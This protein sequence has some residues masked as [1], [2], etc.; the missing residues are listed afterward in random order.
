MLCFKL[1]QEDVIK[2][3]HSFSIITFNLN[4]INNS[5]QYTCTVFSQFIAVKK[6][7]EITLNYRLVLVIT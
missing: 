2:F 7:P 1:K 5:L 6:D 3:N 4:E